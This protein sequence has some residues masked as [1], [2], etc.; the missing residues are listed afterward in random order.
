MNLRCIGENGTITLGGSSFQCIYEDYDPT[1]CD[2]SNAG[3]LAALSCC[4]LNI[5]ARHGHD[6]VLYIHLKLHIYT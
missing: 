4:K 6:H 2:G 1:E 3:N 5:Y